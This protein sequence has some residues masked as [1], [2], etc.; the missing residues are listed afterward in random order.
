VERVV[1][2]L[3]SFLFSFRLC[4]IRGWVAAQVCLQEI[5][6]FRQRDMVVALPLDLEAQ[7][8]PAALQKMPSTRSVIRQEV[9]MITRYVK[10]LGVLGSP[11]PDECSPDVM[12]LE[13]G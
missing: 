7:I 4:E 8:R 6:G 2:R 11:K 1:S 10:R 9:Q 12:K 13:S 5:F 3:Y